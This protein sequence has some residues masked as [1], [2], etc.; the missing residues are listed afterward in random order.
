MK[1]LFL[2]KASFPLIPSDHLQEFASAS[3]LCAPYTWA[4]LDLWE[5]IAEAGAPCPPAFVYRGPWLECP[6]LSTSHQLPHPVLAKT[7]LVF[8]VLVQWHTSYKFPIFSLP[9]L[10]PHFP[11]PPH[12]HP[13]LRITSKSLYLKPTVNS[14]HSVEGTTWQSTK[15][16]IFDR[17]S[18]LICKMGIQCKMLI[19][20]LSSQMGRA[21][22]ALWR[23]KGCA[24][25]E[26]L[27]LMLQKSRHLAFHSFWL[28]NNPFKDM[29][30]GLGGKLRK[31]KPNRSMIQ[32]PKSSENW[33]FTITYLA[34]K[35]G[36]TWYEA[37]YGIY[38]TVKVHAFC[39]R[40]V[41][42]CVCVCVCVYDYRIPFHDSK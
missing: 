2:D 33:K 4:W 11:S 21:A 36:Q 34:V 28:G 42:V 8:Q 9:H 41:C 31:Y 5:F 17:L 13:R 38:Q 3:H 19:H 27:R 39:Y 16:G 22:G 37:I 15:P 10:W 25:K 32:D 40:N 20:C 29:A 1:K 14:E 7:L 23:K 35:P 24:P 6:V 30:N 12:S 18:L 26:T